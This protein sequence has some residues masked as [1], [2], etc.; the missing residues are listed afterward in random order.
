MNITEQIS[1]KQFTSSNSKNKNKY[2]NPKTKEYNALLIAKDS[3]GAKILIK[4]MSVNEAYTGK[5]WNTKSHR[6]WVKSVLKALPDIT[7]PNAP[8]QINFTFGMSNEAADGDNCV[9]VAQDVIATK[10][11]FN[12]KKIRRWVIDVDIVKKGQE[13]FKFLLTSIDL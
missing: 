9:K 7:I 2:T 13:Y 5:K 6:N 10:Y 3:C 1:A 4:P 11:G 8:Y 12:D